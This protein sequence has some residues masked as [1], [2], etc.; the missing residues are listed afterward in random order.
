VDACSEARAPTDAGARAARHSATVPRWSRQ[1]RPA[2]T[3]PR[4]VHRRGVQQPEAAV[5]LPPGPRGRPSHRGWVNS[6]SS[7]T[8]TPELWTRTRGRWLGGRAGGVEQGPRCGALRLRRAPDER[9]PGWRSGRA[10]RVVR[11]AA[12]GRAARAA[13]GAPTCTGGAQAGSADGARRSGAGGR[14]KRSGG[15]GADRRERRARCRSGGGGVCGGGGAGGRAGEGASGQEACPARASRTAERR[16]RAVLVRAGERGV[17]GAD[18]AGGRMARS[19]GASGGA[20]GG[21]RERRVQR[22][23]AERVRVGERCALA[24]GRERGRARHGTL[25]LMI[26]Y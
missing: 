26:Q 4:H 6:P 12:R 3:D 18:G 16:G 1:S 25:R 20:V 8:R 19:G 14:K 5:S 2:N 7:M 13:R 17:P 9:P 23:P 11:G 22:G 24:M 15:A 21:V 10:A